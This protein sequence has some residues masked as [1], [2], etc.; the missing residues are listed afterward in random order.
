MEGA[1]SKVLISHRQD[2]TSDAQHRVPLVMCG[3]SDIVK[4]L[5]IPNTVPTMHTDV[6]PNIFKALGATLGKEW[7]HET[8]Y[9]SYY[10]YD[11]QNPKPEGFAFAQ[12]EWSG[13][14]VARLGNKR[15]VMKQGT[16]LMEAENVDTGNNLDEEEIRN[17]KTLMPKEG[18]YTWPG[19]LQAQCVMA[20]ADDE[21]MTDD[22][23][24]DED[25]HG[26]ADVPVQNTS[27]GSL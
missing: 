14:A 1:S 8:H 5:E 6:L 7:K 10:C 27:M 16:L 25:D 15:I 4:N 24:L 23:L 18:E 12:N 17:V 13:T 11:Q 26:D 20:S 21:L 19:V 9:T 3:L 2:D 22:I